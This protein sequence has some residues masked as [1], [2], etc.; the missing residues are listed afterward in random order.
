MP[1][2]AWWIVGVLI[3]GLFAWWLHL[4][5]WAKRLT[6]PMVYERV[7]RHTAGD[8]GHFE[9]RHLVPNAEGATSVP[10]LLVHGVGVNHRSHDALPDLSLARALVAAGRD[11]WLL[12]LRSGLTGLP[13]RERRGVR[14]LAMADHDVPEA[15]DHVLAASDADAL[16]YVGYS[17]GGMLLYA[18]LDRRLDPAKLRRVAVVGS[19]A[20]VRSPLPGLAFLARMPRPLVPT[21]PLRLAGRSVAFMADWLDTPLHRILVNPKNMAK[22]AS[23]RALVNAIANVPGPLAADFA[24]WLASD[25]GDVAIEGISVLDA[26]AQMT[27]PALFLAGAGDRIAPPEA[28][29]RAYEA[30]GREVGTPKEFV[31]LGEDSGAAEDY[32][33]GDLVLGFAAAHDVFP[34]VVEFLGEPEI[35]ST[36]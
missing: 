27:M 34:R 2:W 14:F 25:D 3:I 15:I 17:M 29:A 19:P 20:R 26:L 11:V 6:V 9:L 35:A 22:G 23:A 36:S 30:W 12:T 32:G 33:H 10:I 4:R 28:V 5:F 8:G 31:L 24:E 7:V 16:D 13:R 1:H 18:A 21:L